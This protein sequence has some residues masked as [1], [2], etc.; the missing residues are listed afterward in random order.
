[1]CYNP[2]R[3]TVSDGEKVLIENC[4]YTVTMTTTGFCLKNKNQILASGLKDQGELCAFLN[5][6]NAKRAF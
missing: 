6:K 5:Q 2:L 3:N 4:H 1:M